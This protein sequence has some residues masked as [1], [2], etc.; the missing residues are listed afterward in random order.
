MYA[1]FGSE[2][3]TQPGWSARWLKASSKPW[4]SINADS[5]KQVTRL[6]SALDCRDQETLPGCAAKQENK[7]AVFQNFLD[8]RRIG[9]DDGCRKLVRLLLV[10]ISCRLEYG[11]DLTQAAS[12]RR[13][14]LITWRLEVEMSVALTEDRWL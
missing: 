11:V 10:I 4:L 9:I 7:P 5:R 12:W 13:H 14:F 3:T 6:I 1:H 2:K 8:S